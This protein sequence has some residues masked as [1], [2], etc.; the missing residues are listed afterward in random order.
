VFN[1]VIPPPAPG[2]DGSA[3]KLPLAPSRSTALVARTQ[4]GLVAEA[5]AARRALEHRHFVSALAALACGPALRRVEPVARLASVAYGFEAV[6]CV[7]SIAGRWVHAARP[8]AMERRR[9]AQVLAPKALALN[10]DATVMAALLVL[11]LHE[12]HWFWFTEREL[13]PPFLPFNLVRVE[14]A[15][16][17][18]LRASLERAAR[19][20]ARAEA[21]WAMARDAAWAGRCD[22]ADCAN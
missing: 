19:R 8:S 4:H 15:R 16:S 14:M 5:L 2:D 20:S 12:E 1:E 18:A 9:V 11:Q 10:V 6:Q 21:W 7:T 17:R 22:C 3:W 13:V